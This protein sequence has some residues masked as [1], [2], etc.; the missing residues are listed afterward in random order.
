[1]RSG[2]A[3]LGLEL[4]LRSARD[5]LEPHLQLAIPPLSRALAPI[6]PAAREL[7]LVGGDLEVARYVG[8]AAGLAANLVGGSGEGQGRI[9][10]GLGVGVRVKG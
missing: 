9:G 5:R 1:M 7:G 3:L 8:R 6:S 10:V 4:A 2:A